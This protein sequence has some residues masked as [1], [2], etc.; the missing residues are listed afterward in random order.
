MVISDK[1]P[2]FLSAVATR[3]EGWHSLV[4]GWSQLGWKSFF[5]SSTVSSAVYGCVDWMVGSSTFKILDNRVVLL[6]GS[7]IL[8]QHFGVENSSGG[9]CGIL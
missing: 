6:L 2:Q 3:G 1:G 5:D 4:D 8:H 9:A 7:S